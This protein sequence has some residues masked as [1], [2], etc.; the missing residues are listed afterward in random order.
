[1]SLCSGKSCAKLHLFS[2]RNGKEGRLFTDSYK[3]NTRINT[4]PLK[5]SLHNPRITCLLQVYCLHYTFIACTPS[6]P[7]M[8]VMTVTMTFKM[9]FQVSFLIFI[10]CFILSVYKK[11]FPPTLSVMSV[12]VFVCGVRVNLTDPDHRRRPHCRCHRGCCRKPPSPCCK[13]RTSRP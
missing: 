4:V 3:S 12:S 8:V 1:M 5:R 13:A 11:S 7:A 6:I 10:M 9:F 2:G